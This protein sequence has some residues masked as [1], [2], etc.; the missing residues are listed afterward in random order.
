MTVWCRGVRGAITVAENTREGVLSATKELLQQIIDA[1]GIDAEDVA[2]VFFTAT[3]DLD[4]E[5][6]AVAA[7]EMGWN[8]PALMC[9]QEMY[10]TGG[11][12]RCIRILI[13]WNTTKL[14]SDLVH[15]YLRDAQQLRPE[16]VKKEEAE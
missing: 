12:Q 15:V 10:V 11:M 14:T 8:Q 2:S 4:A 16:L 7:R 5:F 3:P 9:A 1:N 6:P 13:H